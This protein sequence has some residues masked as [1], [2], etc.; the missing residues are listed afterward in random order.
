[1]CALMR[2]RKVDVS[3]YAN[4]HASIRDRDLFREMKGSGCWIVAVGVESGDQRILRLIGKNTSPEQI[5]SVCRSVLASGLMLK[6]FFIL[7][8]PGDTEDT[9]DRTIDFALSLK[10]HYPVFSLMTPYPGTELWKKAEEYGTFDRSRFDRLLLASS[11]PVFIPYGLSKEILLNK[12]KEAFRKT[13]LN[14]GM[15]KRQLASIDSPEGFAKL[16]KA[17]L[18]FLKIQTN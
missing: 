15:I 7:G 1:M 9:I 12:Q 11:D 18:S 4:I 3:W 6:T 2:K 8:N 14:L 10:A 5:S 17:F 16:F 13:Y